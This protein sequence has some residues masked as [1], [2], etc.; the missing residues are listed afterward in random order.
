LTT[1]G[2]LDTTFNTTGYVNFSIGSGADTPYDVA[3]QSDGMIVVVG[4]TAGTSNDFF[5][6]RFTSGGTLDTSFGGGLG[7]VT[8]NVS[9]NATG[10]DT[11]YRVAIQGD[12]KIVIAGQANG[13]FGLVRLNT[14]GTLDTSFDGDGKQTTSFSTTD[15]AFAFAMVAK[16]LELLLKQAP[17][18]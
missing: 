16:A 1:A 7:Y 17:T 12:G 18:H 10:S 5:A 3:I 4:V 15:G 6:A 13:D 2:A 11:A 8:V 9:T 14:D